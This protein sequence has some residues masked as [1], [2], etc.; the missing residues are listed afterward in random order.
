MQRRREALENE[1][2][3]VTDRLLAAGLAQRVVKE[4]GEEVAFLHRGAEIDKE[5]VLRLLVDHEIGA[6]DQELGGYGDGTRILYDP[7]RRAVHLQ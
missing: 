5:F 3:G 6:G 2:P 1:S 7:S 4:A